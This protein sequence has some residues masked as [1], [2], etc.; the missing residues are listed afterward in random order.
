MSAIG[1]L[2]D[3]VTQTGK[4][5]VLPQCTQSGLISFTPRIATDIKAFPRH[6]SF[7]L[8]IIERLVVFVVAL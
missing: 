8:K 4:I 3:I 7:V 1:L 2:A 5:L 6:I